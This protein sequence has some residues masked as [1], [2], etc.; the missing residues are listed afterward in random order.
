MN[1]TKSNY[2]LSVTSG[3]T[4]L[5][6]ALA[7]L[8]IK[9]NDEIIVPNLTFIAPVNAVIYLGGKPVIVD[10]DKNNLCIDPNKIEKAITNKTKAIMLVYLYGHACDVDKIRAIAKRKKTFFDRGLCRGIRHLL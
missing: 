5:H 8:G 6:L 2:C 10:V 1:L 4:A 7:S 9:K 3:T